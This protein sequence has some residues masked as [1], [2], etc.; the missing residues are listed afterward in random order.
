MSNRKNKLVLRQVSANLVAF[1]EAGKAPPP[2]EG[3]I[4]T[5]RKAINMT[6]GQLARR[7][8]RTTPSVSDFE[9]RER[10]GTITLQSI[11]QIA[12]AMDMKFV[13]AIIP[14]EGSLEDFVQRAAQ[15]K[16]DEIITRT[17]NTMGLEDQQNN[18]ER[19]MEARKEKTWEL[20]NEIPK[21]LWE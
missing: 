13:Y 4:R 15:K 12:E 20:M 14:K 17:N 18:P 9:K 19:L 5:I 2:A 1:Q 8:G 3:W 11:R 7:I 6:L 10:E 16:A 21:F